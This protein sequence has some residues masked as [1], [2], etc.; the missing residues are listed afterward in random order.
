MEEENVFW[1]F[2]FRRVQLE[3]AQSSSMAPE[4]SISSSMTTEEATREREES[5]IKYLQL[6]P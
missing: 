3:E 5:S 4:E 6:I 1:E 2:V